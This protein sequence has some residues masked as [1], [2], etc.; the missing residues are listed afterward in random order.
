MARLPTN[1]LK[2]NQLTDIQ[3]AFELLKNIYEI[4]DKDI[5]DRLVYVVK[6]LFEI[7]KE[8]RELRDEFTQ[9]ILSR[10]E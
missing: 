6:T 9:E 3:E 7:I 5:D 10:H 1:I 8:Q 4:E 2:I